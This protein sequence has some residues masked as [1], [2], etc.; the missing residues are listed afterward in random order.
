MDQLASSYGRGGAVPAASYVASR[1]AAQESGGWSPQRCF[2]AATGWFCGNETPTGTGRQVRETEEPVAA[3]AAAGAVG[4]PGVTALEA[5]VAEPELVRAR[6]AGTGHPRQPQSSQGLRLGCLIAGDCLDLPRRNLNQRL[7][8]STLWT[9]V[10]AAGDKSP[11]ALPG[12][13]L[14]SRLLFQS[15]VGHRP[16]G[17]GRKL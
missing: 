6:R 17:E 13:R 15:V 1:R 10:S 5:R 12:N 8:G 4:V 3:G 7:A 14:V 16:H 2:A 11:R 9:V